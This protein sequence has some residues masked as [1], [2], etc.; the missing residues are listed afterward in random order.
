M[1]DL[2]RDEF[3]AKVERGETSFSNLDLS[4]LGLE[5]LDLSR[6]SLRQADMTAVNLTATVCSRRFI[7]LLRR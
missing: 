4:G 6:L 1:S 2:D 7:A 3:V 5:R